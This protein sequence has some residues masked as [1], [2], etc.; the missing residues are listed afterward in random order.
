MSKMRLRFDQNHFNGSTILD[1]DK[2]KKH[3]MEEYITADPVKYEHHLLFKQLQS[4]TL[5]FRLKDPYCSLV[6]LL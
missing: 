5:E 2:A 1:A 4:L 6:G 3:G